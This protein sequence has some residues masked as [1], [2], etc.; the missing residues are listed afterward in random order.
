MRYDLSP[1]ASF[2]A[3][4][5]LTAVCM[6][7]VCVCASAAQLVSSGDCKFVM[8]VPGFFGGTDLHLKM[9]KG[10]LF[11]ESADHK[12]C[13]PVS[14]KTPF[15][16]SEGNQCFVVTNGE[17]VSGKWS[18]KVTSSNCHLADASAMHTP[19]NSADFAA[20]GGAGPA[21]L[22]GQA[23][24][25]TVGGAVKTCAGSRVL[26]LPATPYV[27]E[28]LAKEKVG[29]AVQADPRLT[30]YSRTTICDAQGNFSFTGLPVK[31]WFVM[32][33]V[34]WGVPQIGDSGDQP[35]TDQQGGELIQEV[36]LAPGDNQAFLTYRDEQ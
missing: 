5:C 13:G 6:F 21:T 11:T 20:W 4:V 30:S 2:G 24:L 19:F 27:D 14:Q 35:Q 18:D 33:H 10:A 1:I 9:R 7:G 28:L 36:T 32:T 26:L 16:A 3:F 22:H 8:H 23:F 17:L 31:R 12:F 34:T 25:K 15:G 29:I